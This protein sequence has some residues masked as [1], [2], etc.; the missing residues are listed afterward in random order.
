MEEKV[1]KPKGKVQKIIEWVGSAIIAVLFAF[2]AVCNFAKLLSRNEYGEGTSFGFSSFIVQ[3]DSMEPVYPVDSAIITYKEDCE[4]I[5]KKWNEI[6]DLNLDPTDE[7]CI[8]LTFCDWYAVEV[9]SGVPEYH[10]QT[11]PTRVVMTHQL[12]NIKIDETKEEG[13]GRYTFF[14]HG[15]NISE[16]QSGVG[17][18]QA[19]TEKELLGVVKSKSAFLGVVSGFI[20]SVWGLLILLLIPCL[21]LVITSVLDIFKAVRMEEDDQELA[22]EGASA[23]SGDAPKSEG[24]TDENY[25][26]L[27][28]QM[29][30][31]MLNGKKGGK[32]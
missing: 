25:E 24:I 13:Q 28:Q 17:Q 6:K 23:G 22:T 27:K 21:Y 10:N 31:E 30:D 14:V 4:D 26:A 19:F 8:N 20:S 11:T 12:F 15:I 18:Y 1:K 3:T 2:T 5:V 32:K 29:I 7:R 9:D 16:H